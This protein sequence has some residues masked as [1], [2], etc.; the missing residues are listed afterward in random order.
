MVATAL[1]KRTVADQ[2]L[3]FFHPLLV[4]RVERVNLHFLEVD[5]VPDFL[6]GKCSIDDDVFDAGHIEVPSLLEGFRH[7][8]RDVPFP[9]DL[10]DLLS[11]VLL[12]F[13]FVLG[14]AVFVDLLSEFTH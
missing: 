14:E 13:V 8:C 12:L 5:F 6:E 10:D 3:I 7:E 11:I 9:E 4:L 1:S 2:L